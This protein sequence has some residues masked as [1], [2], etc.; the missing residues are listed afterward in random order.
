MMRDPLET[1]VVQLGGQAFSGWSEVSVDYSVDQAARTASLKISDFAG[2]MPFLP[3]TECVLTAGGDVLITG[4]VRDCK[5]QHDESSHSVELS[6]VSRTVDAVE[7][8]ID[9]PSGFVKDKDLLAIA[10]EFDTGGIGIV[11]SE[12][13]PKE[14]ASFVNTGQS[15]FYHIEP[16]ARS[17]G[18]LIYDTPEG[19]LRIAKKPR[20]RHAGALSIGDGGNIISASATL[21]ERGRHSPVIV[22]G[23]SSKGGGAEALRI[24]ARAVDDG[25]QRK[26]PRIVVHESEATSAKLKD[27]AERQVKRASGYGRSADVTVSGW[28]DAGGRIFEPHF[29]IRLADPRIYC[30]QDMAIQGVTLTQTIAAGGPGTRATL[31]LVDPSALNGEAGGAGGSKRAAGDAA[32]KDEAGLIDWSS[33]EVQA[34][35][36]TAK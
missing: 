19:E 18:A 29:L 9:H 36:G 5:P 14:P 11:G 21:T 15:L 12:S 3:G 22:R 10:R 28:R 13:F 34:I 23:Q 4:Y 6:I 35:V 32:P 20:G 17:H 1:I 24:E 7:A 26:R 25:V 8:S 27:R 31:S 33:P 16:L 30:D 2:A